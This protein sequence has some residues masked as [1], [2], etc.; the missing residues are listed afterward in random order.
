MARSLTQLAE[1]VA[2]RSEINRTYSTPMQYLSLQLTG[3]E[4]VRH[5]GLAFGCRVL[6]VR[7]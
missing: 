3:S 5:Q 7:L 4:I 1:I 2:S 6:T